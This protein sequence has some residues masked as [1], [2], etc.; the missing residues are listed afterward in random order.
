[1]IPERSP[2]T[3]LS[4]RNNRLLDRDFAALARAGALTN[5]HALD[6]AQTLPEDDGTCIKALA[7]SPSFSKLRWLRLMDVRMTDE[8]V[9]ALAE[10]RTLVSLDHL[11]IGQSRVTG[12]SMSDLAKPAVFGRTL[13]SLNL[14]GAEL[15]NDGAIALLS[16]TELV[17]L[18]RVDV[19]QNSLTDEIA[20]SLLNAPLVPRLK[21]LY[22][23]Q[24]GIHAATRKQLVAKFGDRVDF[25]SG[26][27]AEEERFGHED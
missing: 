11:D 19:S 12:R 3:S 7:E 27:H 6:L 15:D 2:L 13:R 1:V 9:R 16:S 24:R 26:M 8:G 14:L 21:V 18:E 22:L 5:L 10:S 4:L 20:S 23:K 17:A 25:T